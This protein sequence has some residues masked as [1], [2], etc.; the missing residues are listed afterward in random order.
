MKVII[1]KMRLKENHQP[2]LVP[3]ENMILKHRHSNK[4]PIRKPSKL[5]IASPRNNEI[6]FV[7]LLT[8]KLLI[9][10]KWRAHNIPKA[11]IV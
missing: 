9:L 6:E 2:N 5:V 8:L 10:I 4:T 3:P 11:T 1:K 7:V